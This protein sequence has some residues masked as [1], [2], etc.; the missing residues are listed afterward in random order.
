MH[1]ILVPRQAADDVVSRLKTSPVVALLGP[2]Q[3]GKSTLAKLILS[4]RAD[5]IYL[6]L[7]KPSDLLK[8]SDPELYL[9]PHQDHLVCL[10]EIQRRPEIFPVLRSLVDEKRIPGRFL[11]LGSASRDLLRQ[12]SESLAGRISYIELTPLLF[13]EVLGHPTLAASHW[14]RGGFPESL[15]AASEEDS[16]R[17]RQDFIRTFLERD[18]PQL[19]FRMPAPMLERLWRMCAH[20]HAQ[21]LNQSRL[22]ESLG[23]SHTTTRSYLDLLCE[24]FM[25]RLL[26]PLLPNLKKRLVR[27][28][29][30]YVRDSGTVHALLDIKN[31]EELSGHPIRGPSWEGWV[32]ENILS[33][34]PQW[35]ASFY[36][37][38]KGA[39]MDLVL[40]NGK[41]R[42]AV[43]C[44]A[45]SAPQPE[46]GFWSALE[47]LEVH[48][49][50]IIAPVQET[51][52]LKKQV[53]IGRLQDFIAKYSRNLS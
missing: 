28:P 17:W 52:P 25:I 2:R 16:F 29:K 30:L 32:V 5:S 42:V 8:L 49:A 46:A 23:V 7:E 18:I 38:A 22:G 53:T 51:Y 33:S 19:G 43:E 31:N 1:P 36:R 35:K 3:C 37:T 10:D 21:L 13:S 9:G 14:L 6:D 48:E 41:R 27:S 20:H 26:P 47:D 40:E 4:K 50:W 11:V 44:K 12:S 39:E 15:L 24:T 34:C 45:S